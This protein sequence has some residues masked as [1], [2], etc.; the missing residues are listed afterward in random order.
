LAALSRWQS[1]NHLA[2][3]GLALFQGSVAARLQ[4]ASKLAA[5][6]FSLM[7]K[8]SSRGASGRVDL[9]T[10]IDRS[11]LVDDVD[12]VLRALERRLG[13]GM[14]LKRMLT[15]FVWYV[16]VAAGVLL[17]RQCCL[18]TVMA[19]CAAGVSGYW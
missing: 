17:V 9:R 15:G 13:C 18:L 3:K 1:I 6:S 8:S 2:I 12:A 5:R 10:S 11:E 4:R 16:W 7:L 19:R 14:E